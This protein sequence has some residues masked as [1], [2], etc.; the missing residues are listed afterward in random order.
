VL[1]VPTAVTGSYGTLSSTVADR[2]GALVK[3]LLVLL[4]LVVIG[5][6]VAKKLREAT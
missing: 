3:K 4:V 2:L 5:V 1:P 6:A